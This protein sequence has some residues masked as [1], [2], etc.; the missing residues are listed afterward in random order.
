[1]RYA[2]EVARINVSLNFLDK[3]EIL[4]ML[5]SKGANIN[6]KVAHGDTLLN[7]AAKTGDFCE[8]NISISN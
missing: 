4:E 2:F 1:M 5:F 6:A 7:W 8:E 3:T